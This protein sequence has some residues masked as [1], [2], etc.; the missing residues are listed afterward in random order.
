MVFECVT[1]TP[2]KGSK[3]FMVQMMQDVPASFGTTAAVVFFHV[4][5]SNS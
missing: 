5:S 3:L 1:P 2:K 4:V